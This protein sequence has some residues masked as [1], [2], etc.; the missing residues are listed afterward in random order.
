MSDQHKPSGNV[1]DTQLNHKGQ[2]TAATHFSSKGSVDHMYISPNQAIPIVFVPGIMGSPLLALGPSLGVWREQG[3]WAWKPDD[4]NWMLQYG[5]LKP[6]QRKKL[7]NPASTKAI[8]KPSEM[9]D[10][11][12]ASFLKGKLMPIDEAKRRGWGSVMISSYGGI[13]D[14][15]ETQLKY[16]FYRGHLYPGTEMARPHDENDW[17]EL[18]GY[19]CLTDE[20]CR[21]AAGWRFPVYA[22]G[23][24][25][26]DSNAKAAD[27]LKERIEAIKAD[28]RNRLKLKCDQVIL[29][30]HS[31]G[32][33]VT[34]MYA[35]NNEKSVLGI[36]H[37]VQPAI[38]AGTAYAR[39]RAGWESNFSPLHPINS[40][41]DAI[42]AWAL[43]NTGA[44]VAAVFG[45]GA[46]P[47][48]LLPNQLY[49][50]DWLSVEYNDGSTK[51]TLFSLP[52][53]DPY[54][55]I[56]RID[57]RWW[58]LIDP[59]SQAEGNQSGVAIHASIAKQWNGYSKNLDKAKDFHTKLGNYYH[60]NT[61]AHCGDDTHHKSWFHVAWTLTPL[62]DIG[63]GIWAKTPSAE[64]VRDSAKLV[65][66]SATGM[67]EIYNPDS[68]GLVMYEHN[69]TGMTGNYSGD[70]YRA[71]LSS[72]DN[73]GDGTVPGHSGEAPQ[74]RSKF[75]AKMKG[76]GHQDSY[77]DDKVRAA[78]LYSIIRIAA[79]AKSLV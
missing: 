55:E 18:T 77:K 67:C 60:P 30:S 11:Q 54:E 3:K 1:L 5:K 6:Y 76:F 17:G 43:G 62:H 8:D 36:V 48:E 79:Q 58:R 46:G 40:L 2:E 72:Q 34:R 50:S 4:S 53:K 75:F 14:F 24:N 39:V 28:C 37:G 42:G 41:F 74:S 66:D 35:K 78:T 13:L 64:T 45:N 20:E 15:L 65:R 44:E 56:Y 51:R 59:A 69:G 16:I 10:Q 31:M 32:G 22:V 71:T 49:G 26:I 61:Y 21:K 57:D 70:A 38:G 25:W 19:Q 29:V 7:V 47:L 33:L 12:L 63:T 9:D 73:P 68:A 27:F 52:K 23:Y